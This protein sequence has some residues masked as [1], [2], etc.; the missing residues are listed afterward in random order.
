MNK[1]YICKNDSSSQ[2]LQF[3]LPTNTKLNTVLL[4]ITILTTF[5]YEISKD[6]RLLKDISNNGLLLYLTQ[7]FE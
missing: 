1:I 2:P 5:Y 4:L 3:L 6:Q 7:L